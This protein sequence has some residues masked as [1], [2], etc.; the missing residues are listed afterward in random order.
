VIGVNRL[1]RGG[2]LFEGIVPKDMEEYIIQTRCAR[3]G[4]T[5]S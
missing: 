5:S 2:C 3:C 1:K 4:L